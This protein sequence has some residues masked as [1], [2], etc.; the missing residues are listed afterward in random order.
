MDFIE[1]E[2]FGY[3]CLFIEYLFVETELIL[4]F[5][6]PYYSTILLCIPEIGFFDLDPN[7][8]FQHIQH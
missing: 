6:I 4:L 5:G 1:L 3:I 2:I 8:L 7:S